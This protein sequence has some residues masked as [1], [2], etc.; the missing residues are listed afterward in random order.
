MAGANTNDIGRFGSGRSI[1]RVEDA[2]L[3]RGEGRFADN[4][5]TDGE[6]HVLFVRSPHAHARIRSIDVEAAKAMP[7][8]MS[9]VTGA[10]LARSGVKPIANT[11]DFRRSGNRPA[12]SPTRPALAME[13]VRY[14][15]EPV[16]AVVARNAAAGR[17]AVEAIAVDYEPL[18]AIVDVLAATKP[19]AVAITPDAPD[20]VACEIRH[21]DAKATEA[22]FRLAAH[23]AMLDLV[24]QRVASAAIE[25]R[26]TLATF[27][28]A[29]NRLTLRASCQTPTGLRDELADVLGIATERVRVIVGDVGGGFGMKTSLYPEDVVAAFA[30]RELRAPVRFTADR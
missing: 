25:P 24:N 13:T 15:G 6:L 4:V 7:D 27:D 20:N 8:V 19:G 29:T 30:A 16:A 17:D 22:A 10:E 3:L 18:D 28:E 23:V 2:A 9:I 11:T 21:G 12:A 1:P 14:V 26:S 5:R